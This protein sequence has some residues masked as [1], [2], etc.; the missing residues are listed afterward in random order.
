MTGPKGGRIRGSSLYIQIPSLLLMESGQQMW[1]AQHTLQFLIKEQAHQELSKKFR[2]M[3][4]TKMILFWSS[5]IKKCSEAA[6]QSFIYTPSPGQ[7]QWVS[8]EYH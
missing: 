1:K 4:F 5:R 8:H 6:G 7:L 3:W 2:I